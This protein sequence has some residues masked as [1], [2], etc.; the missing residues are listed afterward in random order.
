MP[1]RTG[2][3]R[4][5]GE[6]FRFQHRQYERIDSAPRLAEEINPVPVD[7][8]FRLYRRDEIVNGIRAVFRQ[9]PAVF[10]HGV[11][12]KQDDALCVGF[13]FPQ[14]RDVIAVATRTVQQQEQGASAALI[15]SGT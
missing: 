8:V 14:L 6:I 4:H 7:R 5:D 11:R 3:D 10:V 2:V 12:R 15:E 13:V 1:L 9:P